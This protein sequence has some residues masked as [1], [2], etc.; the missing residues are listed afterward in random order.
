[1]KNLEHTDFIN[2]KTYLVPETKKTQLELYKNRY[3]IGASLAV[4][5]GVWIKK[6]LL[7][8]GFGLIFCLFLE[9]TYRQKFLKPLTQLPEGKKKAK[10]EI[11]KQ[12][13]MMNGILYLVLSFAL[14]FYT[15]SE[16][17][18]NTRYI[19]IAISIFALSLSVRY[20]MELKN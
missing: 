15:L 4:V 16:V 20:F 6:P 7:I 1:M 12:A 5:L 3:A 17:V 14:L 11:N 13:L 18:D 19:L 8:S 10:K 2:K 9:Y